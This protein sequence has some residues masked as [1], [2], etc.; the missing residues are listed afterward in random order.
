MRVAGIDGTKSGWVVAT[1][2]DGRLEAFATTTMVAALAAL[3]DAAAVAID[4]PIGFP[5]RALPGGRQCERDARALLGRRASSVF[6]SPCRDA[7]GAEDYAAASSIN[8]ASSPF[9]LGLSKQ[10]HAIFPK[11]KEVD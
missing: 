9:G 2:V 6:N 5:D 11:M 7:L 8:R 4:M 3:S 10:S 1:L